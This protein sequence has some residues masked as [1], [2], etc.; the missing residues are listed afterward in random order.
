VLTPEPGP[1]FILHGTR[2]SFVK[3]DLNPQEAALKAGG[4]PGSADWRRDPYPGTLVLANAR[5]LDEWLLS[6]VAGDHTRYYAS[7]REAILGQAPNP[8]LAIEALR[9][10]R[11]IELGLV[12]SVEGKMIN[13]SSLV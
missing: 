6:G 12:S 9:V 10:I 1:R 5:N 4:R 11:L 2:G 7:V 3:Y 8:V 13:V